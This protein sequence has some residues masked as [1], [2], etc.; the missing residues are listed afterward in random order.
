MEAENSVKL[1]HTMPSDPIMMLNR[2]LKE[3][4]AVEGDYVSLMDL[5]SGEELIYKV[6]S[7]TQTGNPL[8]QQQVA[9]TKKSIL[10]S[11]RDISVPSVGTS[12]EN[13]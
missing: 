3:T 10:P 6:S 2:Q 12:G 8:P 11:D 7:I 13:E 5:E 9:S 4:G 1:L